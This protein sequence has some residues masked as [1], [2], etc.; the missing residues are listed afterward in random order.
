MY[1]PGIDT[2]NTYLSR[3]LNRMFNQIHYD[4]HVLPPTC[5]KFEKTWKGVNHLGP[6]RPD[7]LKA[8]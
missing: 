6:C 4:V 3:A 5:S 7:I 8:W 1:G 2:D